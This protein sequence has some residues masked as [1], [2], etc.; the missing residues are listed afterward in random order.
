MIF[1]LQNYQW[2]KQRVFYGPRPF[3]AQEIPFAR[4]DV[5]DNLEMQHAEAMAAGE[6]FLLWMDRYGNVREVLRS[7]NPVNNRERREASDRCNA[8]IPDPP[9]PEWSKRTCFLYSEDNQVVM[10]RESLLN[11]F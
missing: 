9:N 6:H 8:A 7:A 2:E 4:D 1:D 11:S 3:N 5:R 10:T